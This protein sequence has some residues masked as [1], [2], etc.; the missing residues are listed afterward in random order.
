VDPLLPQLL[1]LLPAR[2]IQRLGFSPGNVVISIVAP[3]SEVIERILDSV[4]IA[5]GEEVAVSEEFRAKGAKQG[6]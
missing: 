2:R 3:A 1:P 5:V 4:S 6:V